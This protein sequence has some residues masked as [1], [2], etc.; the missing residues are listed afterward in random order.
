[1]KKLRYPQKNVSLQDSP[2]VRTTS[3]T[4][5]STT[6]HIIIARNS[7]FHI[8]VSGV[9]SFLSGGV[10][11]LCA[12]LVGHPLDLIKVRMQTGTSSS[13][14]V[15]GML[16]QIFKKEGVRGIYRGVSAPLVATSP[17]YAVS[18]WGYDMGKRMVNWWEVDV[19]KKPPI[20]DFTISQICMAGG[21]SALPTTL[22]MA[23][24]ERIKCLLQIQ[25]AS[26]GPPKYA[27]MVDCARQVLREGGVR[28]LFK[29]TFATLLRDGPGSIAWF[30]VYELS[31]R[32]FMRIGGVE[33]GNLSPLAV[34]CAGGFA[35]M[36]CWA[37]AIPPDVLKSRYQT[38]PE[39]KY[40]GLYHVY[41]DL[42][43][44]EGAGALFTGIRPAMIRA[45]PANAAC[46]FGMEMS[47]EMLAFMD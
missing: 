11:G 14:S 5:T 10:G 18:F 19:L 43:A 40:R 20:K 38:A 23:P 47:K 29:G 3:I 42:M 21:L 32:E 15:F 12:V 37:V 24:T 41:Q 30:G 2:F 1:L 39:G 34:L 44:K 13:E 45:F 33:S 9:K 6:T 25:L 17:M 36:A 22:L 27:G 28:S 16:S 26:S 31:K 35:G 4:P 8:A 7:I 46:F